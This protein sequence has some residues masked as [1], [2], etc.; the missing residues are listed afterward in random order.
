LGSDAVDY[1]GLTRRAIFAGRRLGA[2]STKE[3]LISF[4]NAI[5]DTLNTATE[6]L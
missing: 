4:E 5:L 1:R 6:R 3:W 2:E